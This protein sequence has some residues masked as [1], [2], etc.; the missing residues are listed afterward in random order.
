MAF[1]KQ[2]VKTLDE[3]F[4]RRTHWLR[5][6]LGLVKPGQPPKFGRKKVDDTI[7]KLQEIASNAFARKLA[8]TE[9]EKHTPKR[10]LWHINGHGRDDKKTRFNNWYKKIGIST[11][12]CVYVFWGNG[13]TL[14]VGK[15][16]SGG[17]RPSSHFEKYWFS[18]VKRVT[19][20]AVKSKSQIPKLECLAIHHFRPIHN[21]N[22]A[23]TKKW[24]KA[25]PLCKIHHSI[26]NE[27]R[28]IFRLR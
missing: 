13:N 10:K 8:K 18:N 11:K 6:E 20:Y 7:S 15:T 5:S 2:F 14:Y 28:S 9:F 16:G 3:L 12:G 26:E 19:I 23:A 1:S 24:T 25:C 4:R 21:K 22:K 17:S 27:L